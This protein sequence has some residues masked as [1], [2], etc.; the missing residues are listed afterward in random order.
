MNITKL[1]NGH[2]RARETV[3]GKALSANFD[4]K[5]TQAEAKQKLYNLQQ[6]T[7][8]TFLYYANQYI[9][10]KSN[11]LSAS[12]IKGYVSL[13][14]KL[15]SFGE[16]D[17]EQITQEDI[18]KFINEYQNSLETDY[19]HLFNLSESE[20]VSKNEFS[21]NYCNERTIVYFTEKFLELNLPKFGLMP[22]FL[23]NE[24][25]IKLK[26]ASA[27]LML[28]FSTEVSGISDGYHTNYVPDTCFSVGGETYYIEYKVCDSSFSYIKMASDYLK[29]RHYTFDSKVNT[30]FIFVN[31]TKE[32]VG[33]TNMPTIRYEK[34]KDPKYQ[35]LSSGIKPKDIDF[36]ARVF[37]KKTK[38]DGK[39]LVTLDTSDFIDVLDDIVDDSNLFSDRDGDEKFTSTNLIENNIFYQS[40]GVCGSNVIT[41]NFIKSNYSMIDN[42]YSHFMEKGFLYFPSNLKLD[43]FNY[44]D[45]TE[46]GKYFTSIVKRLNKDSREKMNDASYNITYRKSCWVI[47]LLKKFCENNKLDYFNNFSFSNKKTQNDYKSLVD[48][49][50][51]F[52]KNDDATNFNYLCYKLTFLIH[53]VYELFFIKDDKGNLREKPELEYSKCKGRIINNIEKIKQLLGYRKRE[54]IDK[55]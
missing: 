3:N 29:Y 27:S 48:E 38:V 47:Y 24:Y 22:D 37:I 52:H 23:L 28:D 44:D 33:Y 42:L 31:F 17:F 50:D 2:Y 41:S 11:V 4:H 40:K 5:P 13:S 25:T 45:F 1:N 30:Y 20:V 53:G 6:K 36:N 49:I 26:H 21:I 16:L 46:S 35:I 8:K 51:Y 9:D 12:T 10:T 15:E 19:L 43:D 32:I 7:G 14:R 54:K 39:S 55:K 18:Q 34:T